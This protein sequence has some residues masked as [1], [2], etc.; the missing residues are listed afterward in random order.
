MKTTII[1]YK[2]LKTVVKTEHLHNYIY[3]TLSIEVGT[4]VKFVFKVSI[5]N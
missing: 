2:V 3:N 4:W 5:I 1:Y